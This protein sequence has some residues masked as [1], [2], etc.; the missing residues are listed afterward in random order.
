MATAGY[1][2]VDGAGNTI[3][4]G[5]TDQD[6]MIQILWWIGFCATG[7]TT[8][9]IN[10]GVDS[11]DSIRMLSLDDIDA[12]SKT[13]MSQTASNG[14]IIFGTNRT[15]WLK[16]LIHWTQDFYRVS[17]VPMIVGLDEIEFKAALWND[18]S[19]EKICTTLKDT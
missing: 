12:M 6:T 4:D 19:C 2:P 3:P 11:W 14:K 1:T 18:E 10:D 17:E 9:V 13:F 16:A 7:Q 15:K 5:I 8:L